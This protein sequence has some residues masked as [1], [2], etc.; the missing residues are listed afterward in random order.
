MG[1][2]PSVLLLKPEEE[3]LAE[4][5]ARKI[6]QIRLK[7]ILPISPRELREE[8]AEDILE[9]FKNFGLKIVRDEE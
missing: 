1:Q 8:W 3:T 4:S 6:I 5:T 7:R 9:T 2:P